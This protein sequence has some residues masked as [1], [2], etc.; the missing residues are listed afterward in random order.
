MADVRERR[1]RLAI[2]CTLALGA[3]QAASLAQQGRPEQPDRTVSGAERTEVVTG[4]I[5]ELERAYVFP[6]VAKRMGA[7]LRERAANGQ[8][9]G[10]TSSKAF[11][12]T[13]TA[14]LQAVSHDKHLH[15]RYSYE[16]IPERKDEEEPSP[17]DIARRQAEARWMNY[18]FE[19]V[20]RLP[21]NVGLLVLNA[22]MDPADAAATAVA[23]MDFLSGTDAL[24]IDLRRNGGGSPE[25]IQLLSTYLFEQRKH[26]NDLYWRDGDRTEQYWTLPYVPGR[27]FGPDKPV[28]ILTSSYT[29][30]AAEEFTYNLKNLKR[31]TIVGE[32][33]GGGAHPGGPARLTPHFFVWI[34]RG[35]AINPVSRTNW[36]GTGV[37]PDVAVPAPEALKNAQAAALKLLAGQSRDEERRRLLERALADLESPASKAPSEPR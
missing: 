6:D 15:V 34:P 27:R 10:I 11:A 20:E 22:F 24:V 19:R 2:V 16:A 18:G 13:V 5:T 4:I 7:A 32:T 30:S 36:E 17:D 9:D 28:Y 33:T 23:A 37:A 1:V 3:F 14:D 31:A 35:R 8:Y 25:M 26:L 29:F 21:G 12:E